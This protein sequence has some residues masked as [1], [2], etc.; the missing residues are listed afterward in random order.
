MPHLHLP[1]EHSDAD[2]VLAANLA[3]IVGSEDLYVTWTHESGAGAVPEV[4]AVLVEARRSNG[5]SEIFALVG[6]G[7][8]AFWRA[9]VGRQDEADVTRAPSAGDTRR[10]AG[11]PSV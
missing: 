7:F 4:D 9:L 6:S 2:L 10:G 11:E 1:T 3:E 8:A 5:F